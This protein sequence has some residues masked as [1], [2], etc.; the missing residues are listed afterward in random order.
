[1]KQEVAVLIKFTLDYD[2]PDLLA[3]LKAVMVEKGLTAD[4]I[5]EEAREE[6]VKG[7]KE[8]V[9]NDFCNPIPGVSYTIEEV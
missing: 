3:E 1:M 9:E 2:N 7:V 8:L 5:R 6:L 4:Q